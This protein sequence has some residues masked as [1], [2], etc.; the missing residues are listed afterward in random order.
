MT[1]SVVPADAATAAPASERAAL[2]VGVLAMQGAFREHELVLAQAGTTAVAVRT[3]AQLEGLDAIVLPGGESTTM[4]KLLERSDL[5]ARLRERLAGGLPALG[6]CAGLI[7]LGNAEPDG[8][9]PTFGLLDVDVERN[10]WGRQPASFE[11][12]VVLAGGE[13]V[14]G[15]FIRAPRITRVGAGVEVVGR[16]PAGTHDG[17]PV[18]VRQGNFMGCTFHPELVGETRLHELFIETCVKGAADGRA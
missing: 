3:S 6:T 14:H 16:L 7:L 9:P 15:V 17:E 8:A 10:A 18:V 1:S 5:G 2:R 11:D 13:R 4:R 12:E